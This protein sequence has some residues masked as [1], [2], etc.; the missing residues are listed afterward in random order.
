MWSL[1]LVGTTVQ[2]I[3]SLTF[4]YL[5][6]IPIYEWSFKISTND[7]KDL[8]KIAIAQ[9]NVYMRKFDQCHIDQNVLYTALMKHNTILNPI[10]NEKIRII[11]ANSYFYSVVVPEFYNDRASTNF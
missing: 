11:G 9:K 8:T 1:K 6:Y 3:H 2:A 10:W 5:F 7:T 4:V